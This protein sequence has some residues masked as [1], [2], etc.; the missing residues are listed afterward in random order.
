MNKVKN[1]LLTTLR[2]DTIT[3]ESF[4]EF[5][6]KITSMLVLETAALL[7]T[8]SCQIKT[9]VDITSGTRIN[10]PVLLIPI[11]R[12]GLA[13][14]PEYLHFFKNADVGILGYCRDKKGTSPKMYYQN[15]PSFDT[16][17]RIIIIDPILATGGTICKAVKLLQSLGAEEKQII[18]SCILAAPQGKKRFETT[19]PQAKLIFGHVDQGLNRDNYIIPGMGDFGDRYFGK[20]AQK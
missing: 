3:T 8:Q 13:M 16:R 17:T 7:K 12:S 14:L 20:E 2:D 9:P 6:Q 15:V 10:E 19:H 11:L 5:T 4:R 18:F 1:L